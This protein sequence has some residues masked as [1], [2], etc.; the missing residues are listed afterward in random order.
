MHGVAVQVFTQLSGINVIGYYQ[1]IM[2]EALGIKG[3]KSLLIASIYNCIGPLASKYSLYHTVPLGSP[4]MQP[5]RSD[6]HRLSPRQSRT[7][8][9]PPHWDHWNYHRLDLRRGH[10]L[11][12]RG[13]PQSR[14]VHCRRLLHFLRHYHLLV[15]LWSNLLG[16][17]V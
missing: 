10:Q 8:Q 5:S 2:Y 12:K 14:H 6:F 9:A 15:L 17:H 7:S 13:W 4:L 1:L 3:S 16:L 11:S